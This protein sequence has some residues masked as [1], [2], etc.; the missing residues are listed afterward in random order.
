MGNANLLEVS[1]GA[2]GEILDYELSKVVDNIADLNTK[3]D[4]VRKIT[5][6]L[7][8]KPDSERQN[9]KMSTQVKSTLVPT[10]NIESA[11]YLTESDEGK[12]LVEL[13]PQVPGQM[14]LD[15][16]E[17]DEPKVIPIKKA[18]WFKEDKDND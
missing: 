5:L 1:R 6:T 9:I 13:L 11:L 10:N 8:L 15:G 4:A 3:A 14:A 17:Q 18:M 7:S 12:A 2:I 16:S